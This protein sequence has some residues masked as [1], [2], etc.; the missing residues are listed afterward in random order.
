MELM[1]RYASGYDIEIIDDTLYLFAP[2]SLDV[3]DNTK[4]AHLESI[5][6][7][8]LNKLNKNVSRYADQRIEDSALNLVA[9]AG[10][11]LR[12]RTLTIAATAIL[13]YVILLIV[14]LL[15]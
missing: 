1:V 13:A 15:T 5:G 11:R 9:P 7:I 12:K 14:Q 8:I 4:L 10:R 3:T 6:D 2:G